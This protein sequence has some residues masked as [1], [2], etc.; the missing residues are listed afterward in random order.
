M[1]HRTFRGRKIPWMEVYRLLASEEG[2]KPCT[3]VSRA[4]EWQ[5]LSPVSRPA[6][7]AQ[8]L[9][10]NR[11]N[12]PGQRAYVA[13]LRSNRPGARRGGRLVHQ[14][15]RR[16]VGARGGCSHGQYPETPLP[17]AVCSTCSAAARYA[18]TINPHLRRIGRC[19]RV[20][21][22]RQDRCL[23]TRRLTRGC[24]PRAAAR[25]PTYQ[26]L[27]VSRRSQAVDSPVG[28]K[29]TT[30]TRP[31]ARS[32]RCRL[33]EDCRTSRPPPPSIPAIQRSHRTRWVPHRGQRTRRTTH[34]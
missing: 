25:R 6:A 8:R 3:S 1:P 20:C 34:A 24:R 29:P 27:F 7:D 30:A 31:S 26:R 19:L 32:A 12:G 15:L 18:S 5:S 10:G 21:S 9:S 22:G 33:V 16:S 14:V 28:C 13:G 23:K 11:P 17:P 4:Y 2:R